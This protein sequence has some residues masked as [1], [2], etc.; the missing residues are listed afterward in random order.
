MDTATQTE[1]KP[2]P[3]IARLYRPCT[4]ILNGAWK[5]PEPQPLN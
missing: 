5:F 2:I 1:R 3:V 4:D